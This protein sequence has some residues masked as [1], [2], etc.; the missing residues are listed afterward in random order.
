MQRVVYTPSDD[1]LLVTGFTPSLP[2][3]GRFWGQVGPWAQRYEGFL[4]GNRSIGAGWELPWSNQSCPG[5]CSVDS[6]KALDVA[7]GVLAVVTASTETV[8]VYNASTGVPLGNM[9]LAAGGAAMGNYT[10]WVDTC[11]GLTLTRLPEAGTGSGNST[12]IA[13]VEEDGRLKVVLYTF[14]LPAG[15]A[16][17]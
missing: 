13:A 1:A 4:H 10:S 11:Y 17:P 7:D 16:G 6:G 9:T 12:Y 15:G 8:H 14:T 3:W 2:N 5:V